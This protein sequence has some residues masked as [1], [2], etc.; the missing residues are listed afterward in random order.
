MGVEELKKP[1]GIACAHVSCDG[2]GIYETRPTSCKEYQCLWLE[3][4]M[5]IGTTARR[6]VFLENDRPDKSGVLIERAQV[7]D[8]PAELV[9]VAR[10]DFK[11]GQDL[12]HRLG[13]RVLIVLVHGDKKRQLMGPVTLIKKLQREGVR[14]EEFS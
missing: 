7:M 8:N 11:K 9:L 13:Q 1:V 3:E 6:K 4:R 5:S 12:L 10:G 2:C 14:I